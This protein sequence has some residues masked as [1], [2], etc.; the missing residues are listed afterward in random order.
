M[1][2]NAMLKHRTAWDPSGTARLTR[3]Q[4]LT[5]DGL[6][7]LQ[8]SSQVHNSLCTSLKER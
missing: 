2:L 5:P 7:G 6:D 3:K 4:L 8:E 1:I